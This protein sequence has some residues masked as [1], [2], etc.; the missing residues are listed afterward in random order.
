MFDKT[1]D[2][3]E[4]AKGTM[5][6][7]ARGT[8]AAR[9]SA[10]REERKYVQII[11]DATEDAATLRV[12]RVEEAEAAAEAAAE[13][14]A[15]LAAADG[16]LRL[17]I[18]VG[19]TT[20]KLAVLDALGEVKWAVYRRH[21]ADVRATIIEVLREA[22]A[23]FPT[24]RMTIAITGSGGLLLSQWL[25]I[26]FVQEVI[27]SKTAVETFIPATDVAIELGGED[28]KIIYFDN[29]I[30]QRMNGTCA[31]GTGAFIDQM[32]ALL[33]TDAGGLN[34]LAKSHATIY[35]IAS[36]C[37]VF[38]KTDV[39]PLL[40]EG[41]KKEDIA[42]SIFQSVVT[43]T[44]SGLACGRPIRGNV[45]FLGGPLQYLPEL[46]R[47]FYET[48]DLEGD[49]I[50]V[51][52]NAHLFV[53][54][55][56]AIAG[57]A[58]GAAPEHLSDVLV[59]LEN[60][61]D[62]Q[63]SEVVRLA[64]LFA[65]DADYA[66]FKA[67]HDTERVRRAP[68]EDYRGVAFLGIDAGSTTFKAA[69]IGEDGALLW[70]TYASNKGDV[71][72]CAKAA[73]AELYR[74]LPCDE[75]AGDPLVRIGHA[76]VTGYGEGL[77]LEALRVDSG[78]IETVAHLRGAQEMLPGVEFILDIGGQDMK[79]LRV[80]DG[81]IDHIMLNEACSSGCGSFI[82]SFATGLNLDVAE[83]A[84][85]AVQAER[86]VDLGS[87]CTVFM[88]SRVKQAQKEGAT[89]GDIAAGL[90]ISVIKNALF[91]VIKIRDPHDV[92]TKV[93]V[94]GGT[95]LNDAVLRAFE[96]LSEVNAVRPDIA[97]N[98]GA[99]GAALL[100][101]DRYRTQ[102]RAAGASGAGAV[103]V[104]QE[105]GSAGE[106]L[107]GAHQ[108][109]SARAESAAGAFERAGLSERLSS[110]EPLAGTDAD[111]D[112]AAP[113]GADE[114][115]A[116]ADGADNAPV[117][118]SPTSSL[119]S[120]EDIEALAPTHRTVRC[121]GCSNSC[122]LTVNDFGR[123]EETGK[124]RRFITGNRCE[125]GE[126]LGVGAAK[127]DVPNLFEYKSRRLFDHYTPLAADE[128]RRGTVGIPRALNMYENYPFWFTFF[129]NLGY[130]VILSDPSTKKTYE[131]G[132]ESM[133][134][135][136]VCY[137]AKLSHG[138]IMNL[139][140]KHPDFIWMPCS[141]WER[142]E[143]DTA[144]NHFNCPI[145]ASY[146]E[147][148]RL[149]IDELRV[150]DTKFVSPWLPYDNKEHLKKRLFVE[151]SQN[152]AEEA[153]VA[154]VP[155]TQAEVDAAV[156]AAWAEDEAFKRD[157]RT[158]GTE[159]LAWME[160]TGTHGIVL[161]GRPYHQDPEINHAIPELLTS[162]GLAVLTE[163]SIAHLGQLERP[164]R[165]VD[166]WMYHTRLYAAAKVATQ[167]RD[168]D[169]IQLNSFGCGL[170]ALT[171]DQVQEVLEAAGKVYT[172]L[173]IDEV[174]NLGAARIR[175]RSLL[176]A[177]KDQADREAEAAS[178]AAAEGRAC[179]AASINLDDIDKLVPESF[180][181]KADGVVRAAQVEQRE[182][183]STEFARPQFTAEMK[184]AGYTILAP[185][186]APYHFELLVPIFGRFGYNVKLLPSVDHG[187]VDAGLKYVN[188]DICYPS[189]LVTGQI[190]EAVMSG[191][192]DT[193]KLAVLITQ[194]GGGCRATNYIALIRK[195]LK[196]VGLGHIPVIALS[197]KDLGEVNPG[198]NITPKML[199]Q[200]VYAL[201]YGDLLMQCLYRT[202]PYEVEPGSAERLFD[203]WMAACKAQLAEGVTRGGFK[204]TVGAIV[205]D[206]DTLPLAGEGTKPRVGVV[207]EILVKFHPTANNQI[208]DVI[209]R[210]GCEAVVPGLIEFF[211]FG[212]AG[213]IFQKDP[214]GRSSKGAV[215]SRVALEAIAK[216][217]KPVTDALKRS[218]RFEPAAD[219]YEL[220]EYASQ[221]LSLCNSM[222]EGWLLTAEMV[223][224][225][226]NGC[227]NV[228]CTQPFACLPNH[229]VGKAV[230]KE[231]RRQ[232][233]ESNIVAVDYDPGASEVN[234]LNRIK[235]M[236]AVAKA[237]LA[238]KEK[239]AR[240]SRDAHRD[241]PAQPT[242][243]RESDSVSYVEIKA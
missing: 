197:F 141:K 33:N 133:P 227:P 231:L 20:V 192:Y 188:N 66:E 101:R 90:A 239:E 144:G 53:A 241:A 5:R 236:I 182:G 31:G 168:L 166:Q 148:L 76:T 99:F 181:E 178:D 116:G 151:L 88:N 173:K 180:T 189:I 234:Q 124:H 57:A 86:P 131:A 63:G 220:A 56:C 242:R 216:F 208:V 212:I 84:K 237:N 219:I 171:T 226:R 50:I 58:E 186:M 155:L 94:Q 70:S 112:A 243:E 64:P 103:D 161:A 16:L 194:T 190:M 130:R 34:E 162:F 174:S 211:L 167:R 72:G 218:Q 77:L 240:T 150:S 74:A 25:G 196:S 232:Y 1:N 104:L 137:P 37:G 22:A 87:R 93:I 65:D 157:I 113:A 83:F 8:R 142:Q 95:F 12:T 125:K 195:A 177:L 143:D 110:A 98:M 176:A 123:D 134:S 205:E 229:V 55:G 223:E 106:G 32:A 122:L 18:D 204:R 160:E 121:K 7:T 11:T 118:A 39:Q 100:A 92:G 15:V 61:G 78:E 200:A 26:T 23:Q 156:D 27:A 187:A 140:D 114:P 28:A 10:K 71:L 107:G 60:L 201:C 136:S 82:E 228:V 179:P 19:S 43:Q 68:L 238:A 105:L 6:K 152:F 14:E 184:E 44:I 67:R 85:T 207:G 175:V 51:P 13:R 111:A 91:K 119:L 47:R 69:L 138:H 202:R 235:L 221:I 38:A 4:K 128:A 62:M 183:E 154:R 97:G 36:R 215:G 199:L 29:G 117:T 210:E 129:T 52:E 165:V 159:T 172:V 169:L 170:D 2:K 145:V 225:V 147:A 146:P 222:G 233:P 75:A 48:L 209:E 9:K 59:R 3:S 79:C 108:V 139:L 17:G 191:E 198:F 96:Q 21:H 81:V 120:L 132:I 158:K 46:R 45:A 153:G 30:E 42:A 24:E 40:N 54:S 185:Q 203:H 164:I 193:D 135:E 206:F 80:K 109:S 214:L 102:L 49:A 217:R 115:L 224:L 213:A 89:V 127:S 163:D 126:S 35:P 149:N 230:I 73:L 41:A